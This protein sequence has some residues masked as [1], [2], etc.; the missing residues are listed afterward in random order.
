MPIFAFISII[1][2]F[3]YMKIRKILA[4]IV[5]GCLASGAF[6][7]V[8]AEAIRLQKAP[9]QSVPAKA[10][11]R[12]NA[13][14][15]YFGTA[16]YEHLANLANIYSGPMD[17]PFEHKPVTVDYRKVD[18]KIWEYRLNGFLGADIIMVVDV[19][20]GITYIEDQPTAIVAPEGFEYEYFH[21][22][23]SNY[24]TPRD[25]EIVMSSNCWLFVAPQYGYNF[26]SL[27][28]KI[29][30]ESDLN[31]YFRVEAKANAST[32]YNANSYKLKVNRSAGVNRAH[33]MLYKYQ[34]NEELS[35]YDTQIEVFDGEIPIGADDTI[36]IP[37]SMGRG[38][39]Y[40]KLRGLDNIGPF[41]SAVTYH[42]Y[43]GMNDNAHQWQSLGTGLFKDK[44]WYYGYKPLGVDL[45]TE[46]EI[47]KAVDQEELYRMKNPYRNI[48]LSDECEPLVH[49]V[50]DDY[51]IEFG[52]DYR[53][54]DVLPLGVSHFDRAN[55]I[56]PINMNATKI[57]DGWYVAGYG[58]ITLP[59]VA[60]HSIEF[61]SGT[62]GYATPIVKNVDYVVVS[63]DRAAQE[64]MPRTAEYWLNDAGLAVQKT[65][66]DEN[67]KVAFDAGK[68][69]GTQTYMVV[70][71]GK[72]SDGK[73]GVLSSYMD[74]NSTEG[75]EKVGYADITPLWPYISVNPGHIGGD[76]KVNPFVRE[77][78]KIADPCK[79][80]ADRNVEPYQYDFSADRSIILMTD[81]GNALYCYDTAGRINY[82]VGPFVGVIDPE[83]EYGEYY[84][85]RLMRFECFTNVLMRSGYT[86][87]RIRDYKP[88]TE[89]DCDV[90]RRYGN[91]LVFPKRS[92]GFGTYFPA[93]TNNE[94]CLYAP[95]KFN[96]AGAS[97]TTPD[98][99]AVHDDGQTLSVGDDVTKVRVYVAEPVT[100]LAA[101]TDEVTMAQF[102]ADETIGEMLTVGKGQT[103]PILR[104]EGTYRVLAAA[105]NADGE[106]ANALE[107]QMNLKPEYNDVRDIAVDAASPAVYYN[108]QGVRVDNPRAGDM[109]IRRQG[110]RAVKV[111]I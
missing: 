90:P 28:P 68:C 91:M 70:A 23:G 56:S 106:V 25:G 2:A 62:E 29:T 22:G 94:V 92:A 52:V 48:Q 97:T 20:K 67:G 9:E 86:W 81:P 55:G 3:T 65:V 18:D 66:A 85:F 31:P 110:G 61:A 83:G 21:F 39:Y 30:F 78:I 76:I 88:E 38:Y 82:E 103:E 108:L 93:Y 27:N 107:T 37:Y 96:V 105:Y 69:L 13:E 99:V 95:V 58:E 40:F 5:A 100:T 19:E 77:M 64:A 34:F 79:G 73:A 24:G 16:T 36:E 11:A 7:N 89:L 51:Y 71:R 49:D 104:P 26:A 59:G 74:L 50:S 1:Y 12:A 60:N 45:W 35:K 57:S 54:L 17:T 109:L 42:V 44:Y 8:K 43:S 102:L 72:D 14:W 47:E 84:D 4:M 101:E 32:G 53:G 63:A 46:V 98:E 15:Q 33:L 41:G 87:E 10:P 80:M 6:A 111:V 75:W